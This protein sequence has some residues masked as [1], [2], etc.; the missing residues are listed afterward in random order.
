MSTAV[1]MIGLLVAIGFLVYMAFKGHSIIV[2][3]PIAAL[4][5]LLFAYGI[6]AHF[7]ATYTITYMEGFANY[8]KNYFPIYL[9]GAIFAKL[10]DISGNALSIAHFCTEKLGKSRAV[11]SV[12]I[13]CAILTYGGVSLFVVAFVMLPVAIALFREA[14][15]PKRLIPGCIALGAFTFTMTALPGSPQ[16]QNTIPMQYFGTDS[17]AAPGMGII[18]SIIMFVLGMMWLTYRANKAKAAGEGYGDHDDKLE[19][20]SGST[21]GIA[22]AVIPI[23]IILVINLA[24]SKIVYPSVDGSYME[25]FGTTLDAYSGTWSVLIGMLVS[26]LFIIVSNFGKIKDK[27]KEGLKTSAIDSLTPLV[28]SCAVVGFGSVVKVLPIFAVV[29]G[30]VL[31]LSAL[32]LLS[33][34]VSVNLLCAMTASASGG[35]SAALEVMGDT[36]LKS[37]IDPQVLH[38][39]ASICSGGLD[40]LPYN[41]ATVTVIALCGMTHKKSYLDMFMVATVV[42]IIASIVIMVLGSFGLCF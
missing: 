12:V 24:L 31:G 38:R 3:A 14:D 10:M 18:A 6:K 17:F 34:V 5:A 26:I 7:M 19:E 25:D 15:V 30:A 36:F 33:E 20:V 9:L 21:P 11:L 41:G 29:S 40:N 8:A 28:N 39:L 4:I 42:P 2:V 16:V 37:G 32:P 22:M 23:L 13:T 35:L 27:I 1:G